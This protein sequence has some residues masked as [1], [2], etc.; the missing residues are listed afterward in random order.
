MGSDN[1][2]KPLI[3]TKSGGLLQV[4]VSARRSGMEP[5]SA[6]LLQ[7][8]SSWTSP[9]LTLCI[10]CMQVTNA[11]QTGMGRGELGELSG[12]SR[13]LSEVFPKWLAVCRRWYDSE[14]S[15]KV[16]SA[17]S[18]LAGAVVNMG[19]CLHP[20][21]PADSLWHFS[22]RRG[23]VEGPRICCGH[24]HHSTDDDRPAGECWCDGCK[25][26][27]A[28]DAYVQTHLLY[29]CRKALLHPV[30][31]C[32][33]C[34]VRLTINPV[35]LQVRISYA[36][37]NFQTALSEKNVAGFHAALWQF[38][39]IIVIATPSFALADWLE[40]C[41]HKFHAGYPPDCHQALCAICSTLWCIQ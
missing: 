2:A 12:A 5:C 19:Q 11:A 3:G 10:T 7:C 25:C 29:T 8:R 13:P 20:T 28:M 9:V 16:F 37:R 14:C 34:C 4:T 35:L 36:Q 30:T 31:T 32:G 18:E 41:H 39:G 15:S 1:E 22:I 21:Q 17:V 24:N 6:V 23:T 33:L 26:R 38:V 27:A 40:V